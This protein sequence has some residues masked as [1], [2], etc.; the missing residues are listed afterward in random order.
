M[1]PIQSERKSCT[2]EH[3][4]TI[5]YCS[6]MEARKY[7]IDEDRGGEISC[8]ENLSIYPL[9]LLHRHVT[10][11]QQYITTAINEGKF[12][13]I[14][15]FSD[16]SLWLSLPVVCRS[17]LF[18]GAGPRFGMT[19]TTKGKTSEL[20]PRMPSSRGSAYGSRHAGC[21]SSVVHVCSTSRT[22]LHRQLFP[23]AQCHF[24]IAQCPFPIALT[25][26]SVCS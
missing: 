19:H 14:L 24:L 13:R 10:Q 15:V 22:R 16:P 23:I 18:H 8:Y 1:I 12:C 6:S 9:Y 7:Q 25:V 5:F 4:N 26:L 20:L 2:I 11:Q 3:L 17:S 21:C